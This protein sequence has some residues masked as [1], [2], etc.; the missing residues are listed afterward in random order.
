MSVCVCARPSR[1]PLPAQELDDAG[2]DAGGSA[3]GFSSPAP[4]VQA[5]RKALSVAVSLS[6]AQSQGDGEEDK[7]ARRGACLTLATL[8]GHAGCPCPLL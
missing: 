6:D 5:Q 7:Y 4:G 8:A 2:G 1:P 3:A